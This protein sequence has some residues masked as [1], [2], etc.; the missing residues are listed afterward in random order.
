M[1]CDRN[2]PHVGSIGPC[3]CGCS[4]SWATAWSIPHAGAARG[5]HGGHPRR[6]MLRGMPGGDGG[7]RP[8][9]GRQA[10]GPPA[11]M[12][13]RRGRLD[14]PFDEAAGAI[15]WRGVRALASAG[16][17]RHEAR[18]DPGSTGV[19]RPTGLLTVS[20]LP[21]TLPAPT[22]RGL[23]VTTM[24]RGTTADAYV[25]APW[26]LGGVKTLSYA[27]NMAAMREAE[28]RGR[29]R[30]DLGQCRRRRPRVGDQLGRVVRRTHAAHDRARAE[31]HSRR[32]H[33]AVVVRARDR[34]GVADRNRPATVEDLHRA[35]VLWLIGSVRGPV[36]VVELDG[37]RRERTPPST[38]DPVAGGLPPA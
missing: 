1:A 32:H 22:S 23:R 6:R 5:R 14:I 27:V 16:R 19:R 30:G 3:R 15:W 20:D 25:D 28:R 8:Q 38:P 4:R 24:T 29:R 9:C 17:G 13:P 10:G 21:A 35:A 18:A 11:R 7:G 2:T 34:G 37:V 33:P 31:W 36:D 12:G 26:L